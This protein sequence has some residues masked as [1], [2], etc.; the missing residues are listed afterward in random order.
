VVARAGETMTDVMTPEQRSRV[1]SRIRGKD[2]TP[3]RYLDA[4]LAASGLDYRRHDSTLPGCPDFVFPHARVAVFIDGDFWHGWR[5]PQWRHKLQGRWRDKISA[6][7]ARDRRNFRRLGRHGWRVIRLW[8][9][10]VEADILECVVRIARVVTAGRIDWG[11]VRRR[12]QAMPPL[13]RRNR[14]PRP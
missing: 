10:Q 1:M 13:K 9:H 3:E 6:N 12:Y 5:F 4:L 14:L 8:E 11:S 7:R 2:T